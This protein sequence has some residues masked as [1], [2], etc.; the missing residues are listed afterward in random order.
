MNELLGWYGYDKVV[1]HQDTEN[2]DLQ[3]FTTNTPG[4]GSRGST[5]NSGAK[6]R[7]S[8][9]D[10]ISPDDTSLDSLARSTPSTGERNTQ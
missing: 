3:R 1:D 10:S 6:E 5:P 8:R 4:S 2:L 7:A 9:R